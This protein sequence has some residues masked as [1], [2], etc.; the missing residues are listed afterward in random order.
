MKKDTY[1]N[2]LIERYTSR[3]MSAIFSPDKKF[4]YFLLCNDLIANRMV[5]N[6][7]FTIYVCF[8]FKIKHVFFRLYTFHG[9]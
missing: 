9:Y 8:S 2:P 4:Y 7:S 6:V 5:S 3:E 1:Q